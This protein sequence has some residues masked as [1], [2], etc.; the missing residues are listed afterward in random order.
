MLTYNSAD[1]KF[2]L[3]PV[4]GFE[5]KILLYCPFKDKHYPHKNMLLVL[6]I[7]DPGFGASLTSWIQDAR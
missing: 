3:Q 4:P 5:R 7:R 6:W 2:K 1:K